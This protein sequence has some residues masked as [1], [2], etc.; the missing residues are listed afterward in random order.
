MIHY[1]KVIAIYNT[2]ITLLERSQNLF[3]ESINQKFQKEAKGQNFSTYIFPG[4][5]LYLI[6][7]IFTKTNRYLMQV[8][9]SENHREI[10]QLGMDQISGEIRPFFS[11]PVSSQILDI[12]KPDIRFLNIRPNIRQTGY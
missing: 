12:K 3:S 10:F 9:R 6:P 5:S 8:F 1:K 2:Q 11:Y 4:K 7:K